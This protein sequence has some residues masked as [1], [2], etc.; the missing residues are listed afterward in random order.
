MHFCLV[1]ID[2]GVKLEVKHRNRI[3][4]VLTQ[5]VIGII[6]GVKV[7]ISIHSVSFLSTSP[8]VLAGASRDPCDDTYCGSKAFSEVETAQV[9]KFISDHGDTIVHYINFHSYSQF[10]MSPWGNLLLFP[11]HL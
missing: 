1:E 3:V 11:D 4:L 8:I 10:W 6:I 2:Y 9:A 7:T 5:T